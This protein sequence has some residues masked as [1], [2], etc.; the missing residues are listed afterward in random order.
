MHQCDKARWSW[1]S[2][3]NK[4]E[5]HNPHRKTLL[6]WNCFHSPQIM[7]VRTRRR[8]RGQ[9]E[10]RYA[11]SPLVTA[12]SAV[13]HADIWLPPA[14]WTPQRSA[15]YLAYPKALL[16]QLFY[17]NYHFQLYKFSKNSSFYIGGE[18]KKADQ[19]CGYCNL[20][21]QSSIVQTA[22]AWCK[23]APLEPPPVLW[24]GLLGDGNGIAL[25]STE[26]FLECWQLVL[27]YRGPQP[28]GSTV[29]H[30]P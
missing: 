21:Q 18:K 24:E 13:L 26:S 19:G 4:L 9:I 10:A 27:G 22:H 15:W 11:Q 25:P 2:R 6:I 5:L 16:K 1:L 17:L 30:Q 20:S 7:K 3:K 8:G 28:L 14:Q 12:T 23:A 29:L